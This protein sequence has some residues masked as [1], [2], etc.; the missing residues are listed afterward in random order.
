MKGERRCYYVVGGIR[1]ANEAAE[2][3]C[4]SLWMVQIW[5]LYKI[6][7]SFLQFKRYEY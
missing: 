7:A 2:G 6:A 5:G 1:I 3:E 4:A